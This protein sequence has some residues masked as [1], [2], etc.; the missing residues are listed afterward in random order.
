MVIFNG[1]K[2]MEEGI[3]DEAFS[4]IQT[5]DGGYIVAARTESLGAGYYVLDYDALVI[6]LD[7]NGNIQWAKTYGRSGW[8]DAF[9]IIQTS[10]GGYIVAGYTESFSA[11][12]S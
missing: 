12:S 3:M 8:D 10:D 5:S 7:S 11:G 2:H 6:K 9:S 4:I 1:L